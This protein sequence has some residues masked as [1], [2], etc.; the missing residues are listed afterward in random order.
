MLTSKF[1]LNKM[2]L[3]HNS[4]QEITY[5]YTMQCCFYLFYI[6]DGLFIRESKKNCVIRKCIKKTV[7][8][9]YTMKRS[10]AEKHKKRVLTRKHQIS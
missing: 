2:P 9:G 4:Q 8:Y 10:R 1:S 5:I 7:F 6:W 3:F